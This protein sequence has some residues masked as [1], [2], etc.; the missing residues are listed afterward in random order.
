MI[1][2]KETKNYF[3]ASSVTSHLK[4]EILAAI[5]EHL[6]AHFN[7]TDDTNSSRTEAYYEVNRKLCDILDKFIHTYEAEYVVSTRVYQKEHF[8]LVR[9]KLSRIIADGILND[10]STVIRELGNEW[11]PEIYFKVSVPF[12]KLQSAMKAEIVEDVFICE[13]GN[14]YECDRCNE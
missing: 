4:N 7:A 11:H 8:P 1:H 12:L 10:D 5:W 3:G 2:E 6:G 13:H 9:E 14:K